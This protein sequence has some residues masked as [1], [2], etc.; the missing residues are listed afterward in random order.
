MKFREYLNEA[1]KVTDLDSITKK[2]LALPSI[3]KKGTKYTYTWGTGSLV[4]D[5]KNKKVRSAKFE[6]DRPHDFLDHMDELGFGENIFS[7]L[8]E[9]SSDKK[10]KGYDTILTFGEESVNE[11]MFANALKKLTGDKEPKELA[12]AMKDKTLIKLLKDMDSR[13]S[14]T[15]IRNI[16]KHISTKYNDLEISDVI[17]YMLPVI[18]GEE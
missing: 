16:T 18:R 10:L 5:I 13:P 7:T 8:K 2:F 4:L 15:A 6:E 14:G 11:N 17:A 12:A 3:V 1:N 9:L